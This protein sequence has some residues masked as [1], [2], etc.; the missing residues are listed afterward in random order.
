MKNTQQQQKGFTLI[1]LM[2]VIAII[3]ILASIAIPAYTGY[4]KSAKISGLIENHEN[5]FRLVKGEASKIAG[6]GQCSDLIVQLNGADTM[7]NGAKIAIG[8]VPADVTLAYAPV[9]IPE[10]GQIGI[11]G[12]V[13]IGATNNCP[14]AGTEI[15]ITATEVTGTFAADYPGGAMIPTKKF[16]PE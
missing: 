16:T 15:T 4:I 10:A 1:E 3:G 14:Q 2:I 6:G 13:A 11:D 8:S 12:L 5:A 9:L 7:V